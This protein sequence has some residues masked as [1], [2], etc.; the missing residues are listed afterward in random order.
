M[1]FP[2]KHNRPKPKLNP[3]QVR[4]LHVLLNRD[5]SEGL[6]TREIAD[7][8]NI[9]L[10]TLYRY[11]RNPDFIEAYRSSVMSIANL[12]RAPMMKALIEGGLRPG[13]GQN[14][15]QRTFWELLGELNQKGSSVGEEH[16]PLDTN[17][18]VDFLPG[19]VQKLLVLVSQ[20]GE[21]PHDLIGQLENTLDLALNIKGQTIEI[22]PEYRVKEEK[23]LQLK[24]ME[25]EQEQIE[26]EEEERVLRELMEEMERE[27]RER[28]EKGKETEVLTERQAERLAKNIRL[29]R[30]EV[31]GRKRKKEKRG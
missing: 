14:A 25:E 17:V 5:P 9:G 3:T 12:F 29:N 15:L 6:Q 24:A 30:E 4:I 13:P 7:R 31:L 16:N 27:E 10:A 2:K 22:V 23:Q 8:A 21:L 1:P 20:G 11:L 28:K 26:D 19:Y 18:S